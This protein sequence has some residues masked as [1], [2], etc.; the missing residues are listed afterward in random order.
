V[1]RRDLDGIWSG[2]VG[3]DGG[4]TYDEV[5]GYL[6]SATEKSIALYAKAQ[7]GIG[8]MWEIPRERIVVIKTE[9][10]QPTPT[11]LS[12]VLAT[13]IAYSYRARDRE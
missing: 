13:H 7:S 3:W 10:T 6:L 12:D 11:A 2:E 5:H 4:D 1:R 8:I 9:L